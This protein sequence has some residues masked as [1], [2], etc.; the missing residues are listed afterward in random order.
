MK[1]T[2]NL[3]FLFLC[4]ILTASLSTPAQSQSCNDNDAACATNNIK[5]SDNLSKASPVAVKVPSCSGSR[6]LII[7]SNADWKKINDSKYQVF[8]VTPGN[9]KGAGIIR[10]MASGSA[11]KPRVI[12]YYDSKK[13]SKTG[14]PLKSK[15]ATISGFGIIKGSHWLI[16]GLHVDHGFKSIGIQT[17]GSHIVVNHT[18][19]ERSTGHLV[20]VA[21]RN[22]V[23]QN[24]ILRNTRKKPGADTNCVATGRGDVSGLKVVNNE[25]Y[26]CAGDGIAYGSI[27]KNRAGPVT[28]AN[29]DIYLTS[30]MYVN[31]GKEACAENAFDIKAGNNLTIENN[32]MWGFRLTRSSCAGSGS[33][34]AAIVIH[35]NAANKVVLRKNV[36]MDVPIC[37]HNGKG[38]PK[39]VRFTDNV[40]YKV[41]HS[42]FK[43]LRGRPRAFHIEGG[44]SGEFSRN[45]VVDGVAERGGKGRNFRYRCN[46]AIDVDVPDNSSAV[47]R[48]AGNSRNSNLCFK[49]GLWTGGKTICIPGGRLNQASLAAGC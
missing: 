40:C 25:M 33:P 20:R 46:V 21:S 48:T 23:I 15:Q 19:L 10:L 35:E 17:R 18:L 36:I 6:T 38:N 22:V 47:Y 49:K 11:S 41:V 12:R 1:K 2:N 26:D 13:P 4:F 7:R 14:P 42:T 9:Y 45:V 43:N 16:D 37:V 27:S 44:L 32:R 24:S 5:A 30:K 28:F 8:C 31:G 34:G 3:V 29:N 39:N